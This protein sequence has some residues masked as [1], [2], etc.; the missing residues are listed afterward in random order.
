[1]GFERSSRTI[2]LAFLHVA[3]VWAQT[4]E[5]D[6]EN[7]GKNLKH[8]LYTYQ[9]TRQRVK[10][11]HFHLQVGLQTNAPIVIDKNYTRGRLMS[12]LYLYIGL[13]DFY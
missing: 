2:G 9:S 6:G 12:Y 7:C 13:N 11:A 5:C 8:V 10:C 1:M 4:D 3:P